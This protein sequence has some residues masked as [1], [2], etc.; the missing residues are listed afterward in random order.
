MHLLVIPELRPV[1]LMIIDNSRRF[2]GKLCWL[3]VQMIV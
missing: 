1:I 3:F 2:V